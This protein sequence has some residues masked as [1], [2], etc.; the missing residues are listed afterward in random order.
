MKESRYIE[1]LNLYVDHQL[2]PAEASELEAEVQRNPERRRVYAQYCRMQKACTLLFEAERSLA[3]KTAACVVALNSRDAESTVTP[4]WGWSAVRYGGMAAALLAVGIFSA[5]VMISERTGDSF[6]TTP[7]SSAGVLAQV[8]EGPAVLAEQPVTAIAEVAPAPS[9]EA[10][11]PVVGTLASSP[12]PASARAQFHSLLVGTTLVLSR[13]SESDT[14]ARSSV[15]LEWLNQV[16]LPAVRTLPVDEM[17][18]EES[19]S[20]RPQQESRV[21]RSRQPFQ[22]NAEMISFQFQR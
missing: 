13:I 14:S 9:T 8:Q 18:F 12:A 21:Y 11:A 4:F 6:A 22:G 15:D 17:G 5:R 20:L 1:L 2:T 3:P 16:K 10:A 7:S 19:T